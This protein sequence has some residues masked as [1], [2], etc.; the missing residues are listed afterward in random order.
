MVL[1]RWMG[2]FSRVLGWFLC[3][4]LAEIYDQI[5]N[6]LRAITLPRYRFTV[7]TFHLI[8]FHKKHTRQ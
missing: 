1:F 8:L 4:L 3:A 5:N 7:N 2:F 6:T